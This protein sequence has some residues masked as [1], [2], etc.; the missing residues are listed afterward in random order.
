MD[1]IEI[2]KYGRSFGLSFAITSLFSALLVVIKETNEKTVL[3]WMKAATPHH[4]ITH[5]LLFLILFVVLGLV[6]AKANGGQGIKISA[7]KL[8]SYIVGAFV[9]SGL[10][11]AGF[12]LIFG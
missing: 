3:A 8:N 10:I 9:I 1:N 5:T 4:W 2:G 12:F 11:I 6:L 7:D